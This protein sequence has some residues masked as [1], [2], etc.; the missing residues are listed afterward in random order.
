MR[1]VFCVKSNG[2]WAELI[3]PESMRDQL[4]FSYEIERVESKKNP[5]GNLEVVEGSK[6]GHSQRPLCQ[7]KRGARWKTEPNDGTVGAL[8]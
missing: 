5:D 8:W 3:Q 7:E 1:F 2:L 4:P 6:K